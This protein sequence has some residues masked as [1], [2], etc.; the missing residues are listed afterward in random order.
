MAIGEL[1]DLDR[2]RSSNVSFIQLSELRKQWDGQLDMLLYFRDD[3]FP[4]VRRLVSKHMGLKPPGQESWARSPI[5]A[6]RGCSEEKVEE[7]RA[8]LKPYRY[9]AMICYD[10]FA[11]ET[12]KLAG[13]LLYDCGRDLCCAAYQARSPLLR[14]SPH[15]YELAGNFIRDKI[16]KHNKFIAA[17]IRPMPDDC[18]D[19]WKRPNEDL[20]PKEMTEICRTDFMYNRFVPNLQALQRKHNISTVFIMTHPVI[21]PRVFRMLKAGG[22]NPVYMDMAEL[23]ASLQEPSSRVGGRPRISTPLSVSLLAVVEEAVSAAATVFMGTAE[24][25][26]TGMIVQERLARGSPPASSYYMSRAPDCAELPCP[27]PGYYATSYEARLHNKDWLELRHTQRA[28]PPPPLRAGTAQQEEGAEGEEEGEEGEE[29]EER[30]D[31]GIAAAAE[32]GGGG[33][34]GARRRDRDAG[35]EEGGRAAA[36]EEDQGPGIGSRGADEEGAGREGS[37]SVRGRKRRREE[38]AETEEGEEEQPEET[39]D[40][41]EAADGGA[42]RR[43]VRAAWELPGQLGAAAGRDAHRGRR[44]LGVGA[45]GGGA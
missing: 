14:K 42:E 28:A 39:R 41:A 8:M 36:E 17:H 22:I 23:N 27:L 16:G 19:L 21:R 12:H 3:A 38:R 35:E 11:V 5:S 24:S 29:A 1:F 32:A 9:V 34:G 44:W 40:E 25:S 37:R 33:L 15:V 4:A 30:E 7:L 31:E 2:L 45:A 18:V 26:M 10:D 13:T 20:D 6:E 43:L